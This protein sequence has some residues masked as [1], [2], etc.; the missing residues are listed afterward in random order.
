MSDISPGSRL[1]LM[2]RL[3]IAFLTWRRYLQKQIAPR[4]VTL[5]QQFVLRQLSRRDYLNPSEIAGMLYCDRPT[6]SVVIDN[7][8]KQGWVRREKD[9]QN[10]KFLRISLTPAGMDK[11]AELDQVGEPEFDPL[12]CFNVDEKQE[13]ERLLKKLNQHLAQIGDDEP[14]DDQD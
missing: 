13:L 8:E 14:L 9:P 5:K 1:P 6:A 4:G 7:L 11:L 12:A 3:G 2:S 10:R